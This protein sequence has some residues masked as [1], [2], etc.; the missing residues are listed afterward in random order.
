MRRLAAVGGLSRHVGWLLVA[1]G[2]GG[3]AAQ[4]L[5][6]ATSVSGIVPLVVCAVVSIAFAVGLCLSKT[7]EPDQLMT[8]GSRLPF[9][10]VVALSTLSFAMLARAGLA[11]AGRTEYVVNLFPQL[12][13]EDNAKWINVVSNLQLG[14]TD[15]LHLVGGVVTIFLG[16]VHGFVVVILSILG[17]DTGTVGATALT[18]SI[19]EWALI[20]LSPLALSPLLRRSSPAAQRFDLSIAAVFSGVL[21]ATGSFMAANFGHLTAQMVIL[22]GTFSAAL[23]VTAG[24]SAARIATARLIG[25]LTATTWL[26]LHPLALLACIALAVRRVWAFR[27]AEQRHSVAIYELAAVTLIGASLIPSLRYVASS[28]LGDELAAASG[29]TNG[30]SQPLLILLGVLLCLAVVLLPDKSAK[31]DPIRV[32]VL[33]AIALAGYTFLLQ[34]NDIRVTAGLNYG[35]TKFLWVMSIT[36]SSILL[37]LVARSLAPPFLA[38]KQFGIG[39]AIV[40]L[41]LPLLGT[42]EHLTQWIRQIEP[43]RWSTAPEG[44]WYSPNVLPMGANI[45]VSPIG[46][47]VKDDV[48]ALQEPGRSLDSYLCSRFLVSAAGLEADM[49]RFVSFSLGRD[50][51]TT[52]VS[53]DA[54]PRELANRAIIVLDQNSYVLGTATLSELTETSQPVSPFEFR[55]VPTAQ[56]E[57][58]GTPELVT[59]EEIV[60]ER[61]AVSGWAGPDIDHFNVVVHNPVDMPVLVVERA[62]RPDVSNAVGVGALYSGFSILVDPSIHG[63]IK[64]IQAVSFDGNSR[65]VYPDSGDCS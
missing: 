16:A 35:S 17:R 31:R 39:S 38:H 56:H 51:W 60:T 18:V 30:A 9:L 47:V 4:V 40:L 53:D 52:V 14:D 42:T 36:L 21:L 43:T 19:A 29:A 45:D 22:G 48:A 63:D 28:D 37:V 5:E 6:A 8:G 50:S 61:G 1:V 65:I 44:R 7:V 33:T 12:E 20:V 34:V 49:R 3:V 2:I 24:E 23:F 13:R 54:L 41:T 59:I 27:D 57:G 11:Y 26:P 15:G 10:S 62:R 55:I 64:C 46:C 58:Q 32:V 25:L